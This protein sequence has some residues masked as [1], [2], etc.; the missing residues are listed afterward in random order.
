MT[1]PSIT[2]ADGTTTRPTNPASAPVV[3]PPSTEPTTKNDAAITNRLFRPRSPSGVML[4][5][6]DSSHGDHVALIAPTTAATTPV[7][8]TTSVMSPSPDTGSGRPARCPR[9]AARRRPD[10]RRRARLH[11]HRRVLGA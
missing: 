6:I 11:S 1:T 8:T 5:S 2:G 3:I 9:R 7:H 4:E 10:A